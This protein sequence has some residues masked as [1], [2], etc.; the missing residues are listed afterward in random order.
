MMWLHDHK[1]D[2]VRCRLI[3][4]QPAISEKLDARQSFPPLMVTNL[5]WATAS[6]MHVD[7]NDCA[8]GQFDTAMN[9]ARPA[10]RARYELMK[11]KRQRDGATTWEVVQAMIKHQKR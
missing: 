10:V 2:E 1:G 4:T 11:H 3:A 6:L 8:V 7:G 9:G 5:L